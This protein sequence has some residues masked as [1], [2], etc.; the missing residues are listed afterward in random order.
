MDIYGYISAIA[1]FFY[2]TIILVFLASKRNRIINA[3][4]MTLVA[5]ALWTGGSCLMRARLWPSYILWYHV[6][7]CGLL[8]LPYA[9]YR[10]IDAFA[11]TKSTFISKL[12]LFILLG[13]FLM[14]IPS[15]IFLKWPE[16]VNSGDGILF[17]YD[18]DWPVII[19]FSAAGTVL[20]HTL[21]NLFRYCKNSR[22]FAKQ[23]EF[24]IVGIGVVFCGNL[25]LLLPWF[26]GFPVDIL[27]GIINAV[28]LVYAL[29]QKRLFQ[30][31]L[32]VSET[33]C[34][35]VGLVISFILF[36]FLTPYIE[37]GLYRL[38]PNQQRYY[39]LICAL[40]FMLMVLILAYLWKR[41]MNNV[42]IKE[43]LHQSEVLRKFSTSVSKS[44]SLQDI[45]NQTIA[46]IRN[47]CHIK[48][49]YICIYKDSKRG[50]QAVCSNHPLQDI[51]FCIKPS[52]PLI[53]W[54]NF[55]KE[56]ASLEDFRHTVEYKSMWESEKQQ[57]NSLNV[58]YCIGL[59]NED[60]L[61]GIMF[62]SGK[63]NN[64]KIGYQDI[65][66]LNSI[67]TVS[68]IAI[69]NANLY[70]KIY[71]EART[72]E[73]TGLYN[74][75]YFYEL[76]HK[77]FEKNKDGTL[78]LVILN[79]DDFKLYNQ[80]YGMKAGDNA[81]KAIADIISASVGTSGLVARYGGKEFAIL[82]PKYDVY[83]AKTLTESICEQI[84]SVNRDK[85]EF[86]LKQLT[87]SAGISAAPYAAR[88]EKELLD[89][90]DLA[91][92]HVK[93]SGKNNIQIY[94]IG[95]GA[96]GS[97]GRPGMDIPKNHEYESTIYALT[98]AIDA[99]DHYTF[100]HSNNVAYY[101]TALAEQLGLNSDMVEIIRQAALMHDVG[102]IGI[103]EQVLCKPGKLSNEE[104]ETIKG[105]V[106]ASIEIIRH[107]PA[108]DYVIPAVIGH[109]ERYDGRGYPRRIAGE[110]IPLAARILGIA[111]AFDA[112]VSR[113][114]Y[115]S[116][117]PLEKT[118]AILREEAGKQFDPE[119][120]PVFVDCIQ[121]GKIKVIKPDMPKTEIH[122]S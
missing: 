63:D 100:N 59:R 21:Y 69:K 6:S 93:H 38:F 113:R 60:G 110:D 56:G 10:L 119:M 76:L 19:L 75:K 104:Y 95:T 101:S 8:M 84:R 25:A 30:V 115:K 13:C 116:A 5:M 33:I 2:A 50:Y 70:E 3:F 73:L 36:G 17:V 15:G 88:T 54:L 117:Y 42:F 14:N 43:E 106:E 27:S 85:E 31:T 46:V 37:D 39:M 78:V 28:F 99:K 71:H 89:N 94:D 44:L 74:R 7:L 58:E 87:V 64:R 86:R 82:L 57:L 108:L 11:E 40:I 107:L 90:A 61:I 80:L 1:L 102:K 66:F 29:V 52:N 97:S 35:G 53:T 114:C 105:H 92:Y 67:T 22:R 51:S 77:E 68:S 111:D 103:P 72:D 12:Y 81:L 26:E 62:L 118:L 122:N 112:M 45:L 91:V 9:Y 24:V 65:T 109:H 23:V 79:L 120:I 55:N 48:T 34:Y 83:G 4:L 98:A 41:V 96:P 49:V 32:L 18:M 20:I 121:K 47:G 16:I